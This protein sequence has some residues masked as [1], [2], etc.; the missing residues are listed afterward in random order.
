MIFSDS[1]V[2]NIAEKLNPLSQRNKISK[3][4]FERKKDYKTFLDFIKKNT[5]ELEQRDDIIEKTKKVGLVAG[6]LGIAALLFGSV[7][8]RKE[9]DDLDNLRKNMI[10]K[11]LMRAKRERERDERRGQ[12]SDISAFQKIPSIA[13]LF[14]KTSS[15]GALFGKFFRKKTRQF[16]AETEIPRNRV[17]K[18]FKK[19]QKVLS[20]SSPNQKLLP[21]RART[22]TDAR[23]FAVEQRAKNS[24]N[25]KLSNKD[26][27]KM[28]GVDPNLFDKPDTKA[29]KGEVDPSGLTK[30]IGGGDTI[31]NRI[32]KASNKMVKKF[33]QL[34]LPFSNQSNQEQTIENIL[35]D[36]EGDPNTK[37]IRT[38]IEGETRTRTREFTQTD[39]TITKG[40]EGKQ[41]EI[42]FKKKQ[43][44]NREMN[45]KDML[46]R[47]FN[48][49]DGDMGNPFMQKSQPQE[50]P[51]KLTKFERFNRFSNRVLNSP[52]AKFTTFLGGL[53][54]SP[55]VEILKQLLT[56]TQL[57]PTDKEERRL[58]EESLRI[59][60]K[61]VNI[62]LNNGQSMLPFNQDL[63]L[64][65]NI[66]PPTDFQTPSNNIFI[67]PKQS[68]NID[69]LFF[70]KSF[71]GG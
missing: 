31:F 32:Q 17:Q 43:E 46:R 71:T 27:A 19:K 12:G 18:K 26:I 49:D 62:F 24:P 50:T 25:Q 37:K 8:G 15:S 39:K 64:N 53:F 56:P 28:I 44:L 35:R 55:K 36:I 38:E 61:P 59:S 6:G 2:K 65:N 14:S 58:I 5:K 20:G 63:K 68:L 66:N 40:N 22:L 3:L 21:D 34:N 48:L 41:L 1:P 69:D 16:N 51:K 11:A 42:D 47:M 7:K 33:Q 70:L 52:A 4:K 29:L 60:N 10:P 13:N 9:S 54:A 45:R 67:D 30:K 57:G 23:R